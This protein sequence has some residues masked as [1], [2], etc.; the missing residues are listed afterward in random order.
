MPA[1]TPR[2]LHRRCPR[3][4]NEPP[5]L[6]PE[7]VPQ[8]VEE[9]LAAAGPAPTPP[10]A[11]VPQLASRPRHL[12]RHSLARLFEESYNFDFFQAVRLLHRLEPGRVRVGRNGPPQAEAVRFRARISLSFPPSAIYD[13]QR[14]TTSLPV[15][16]MVQA[17]MGLTGPS[18]VLRAT[19]PSC[20]TRSSGTSALPRSMRYATGSTCSTIGWSRSSIRPGRSI[21]SS[22]PSSAGN[23]TVPSRTRSRTAC[24]A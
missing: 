12:H 13:L 19:I 6:E 18:G 8:P 4:R 3:R 22:S 5:E 9:P 23:M 24:T 11:A 10:A 14:P 16:V 2:P 17:F 1:R 7:P 15:P 20:S 21:I